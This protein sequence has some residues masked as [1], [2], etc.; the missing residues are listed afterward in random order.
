LI[1]VF[2]FLLIELSFVTYQ[3]LRWKKIYN[4]WPLINLV[5]AISCYLFFPDLYHWSW[6]VL[7]FPFSV[8]IIGFILFLTGVVGAGDS[9]FI[10]S[11]LC[12]I[13]VEFHLP[14]I[15][16]LFLSTILVG[17]IFFTSKIIQNWT[18][19]FLY[20]QLRQVKNILNTVRSS[21]SFAPVILL[22]WIFLG[23]K[24]WI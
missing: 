12:L 2:L 9:K 4:I 13:P 16:N 18:Q 24:Q 23:L 20:L 15:E 21:F 14:Y 8:F 17:G 10:I 3:D 11:L 19:I 7:F 22:A 5:F 1:Y 6:E